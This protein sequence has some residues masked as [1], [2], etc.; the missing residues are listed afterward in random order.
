MQLTRRHGLFGLFAALLSACT[1]G[2]K[3]MDYKTIKDA[4]MHSD[5]EAVARMIAEGYDVEERDYRGNTALNVAAKTDQHII[6]EM[7]LNAG[8]DP[9]SM[10]S[11]YFT[12]ASSIYESEMSPDTDKGQ[13]RLRV[14]AKMEAEGVQ[15]PPPNPKEFPQAFEDGR[16]PKHAMPP[17]LEN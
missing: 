17:P 16:W 7:L 10:D 2:K 6:A 1:K 15:I 11:F 14:L 3:S 12:A 4:V 13:A 9:F 5:R 8:A